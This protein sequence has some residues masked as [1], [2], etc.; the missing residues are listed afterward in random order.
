MFD[1]IDAALSLVDRFQR[2]RER[3]KTPIEESVQARFVRLFAAHGVHRNQIPRFFGNG[4]ELADVR[5]DA[6]L[7][8][9][10]T[11]EHLLKAS[12][13]FGVRLEWLESGRGPAQERLDFYKQPRRFWDW[14]SAVSTRAQEKHAFLRALLLLPKGGGPDIEAVLLIAE[15]VGAFNDDWIERIHWVPAGSPD[16]WRCRG[17]LA[18]YVAAAD[19]LNVMLR[20]RRMPKALLA[21][22]VTE[23]DLV[24]STALDDLHSGRDRVEALKWLE[25]P[26]AFLS[27]VDPEQNHFGVQS[28]LRLWL[29]LEAEG[30]MKG[31]SPRPTPRSQF[32]A[33]LQRFS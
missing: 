6:T 3:H 32:E 8:G 10:L 18:S 33:V 27:G 11:A 30:L 25:D 21:K 13:L 23:V 2:W 20:A 24:G 16:Y 4:I 14:L 17:Y 29:D 19:Q 7:A 26:K 9:R 1:Q 15:P 31:A 28:A 12:E 5:D 22:N